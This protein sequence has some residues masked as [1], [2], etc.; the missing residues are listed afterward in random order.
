MSQPA[1]FQDAIDKLAQGRRLDRNE[2]LALATIDKPDQFLALGQ[3]A[4]ANRTARFENRA[5]FVYNLH[6]NPSNLCEGGCRF[7]G[8]AKKP[9]EPDAYVLSENQILEQVSQHQ[10]AEVHIVGGLNHT[11]TFERSLQL[12]RLLRNRFRHLFIKAFT[13]VELDWFA[14]QANL[15]CQEVLRQLIESGV[16]GLPGGGAE[17]FAKRI[18]DRLCPNKLSPQG[19]L[20]IHQ[21]AHQLGIGT[22]ATMLAGLGET[23][24]ERVDHLLALRQAQDQSPGFVSFIPLFYQSHKTEQQQALSP[25]QRLTIIALARGV[26]DN[27]PHIKAYWPMLG[28]ET[29]AT[30]LSFGADDLDG[31]L[32]KERIVHAA[33][34]KTPKSLALERLA[35]TVRI[36]GFQ[37]IERDGAFR[38]IERVDS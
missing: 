37:P 9:G 3:A 10:P 31:T 38:P 20:E 17:V 16:D 28:L 24:E 36:G 6:I 13:A 7:C 27:V 35:Q 1:V 19:F 30:A 15:D 2:A 11:W 21:Q 26:L 32:G 8:Y 18:R 33:G 4:Y 34:A 25:F 23:A 5:T 29:A 14:R 22:N 12:I